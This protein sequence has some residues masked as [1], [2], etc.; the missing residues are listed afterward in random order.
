MDWLEKLKETE[1]D[2]NFLQN[3]KTRIDL[4]VMYLFYSS[5]FSIFTPRSLALALG[6]KKESVEASLNNLKKAGLL[7]TLPQRGELETIFYY[8]PDSKSE[9]M[10]EKLFECLLVDKER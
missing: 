5:P 7:K 6:R 10:I 4:E 2:E 9:K 8:Q 1:L 3:F